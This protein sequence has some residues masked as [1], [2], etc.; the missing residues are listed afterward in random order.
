MTMDFMIFQTFLLRLFGFF[1]PP[2]ATSREISPGLTFHRSQ[3][4]LTGI[5]GFLLL[6]D[7][8]VALI[9]F[10]QIVAVLLMQNGGLLL[11]IFLFLPSFVLSARPMI[12]L[13]LV[14]WKRSQTNS[15][16]AAVQ[17][18]VE[19]SF[20]QIYLRN[21][22]C[23]KWRKTSLILFLFTISI[24]LLMTVWGSQ[25]TVLLVPGGASLTSDNAL[26]PLPVK[27]YLWQYFTLWFLFP[28]FS[29]ILSQQVLV[30]AMLSALVLSDSLK[31]LNRSIRSETDCLKMATKS[32]I[33][34]RINFP[35][36]QR[37]LAAWKSNAAEVEFLFS[38]LNEYFDWILFGIF[39]CD[40]LTLMGFAVNIL[41]NPRPGIDSYGYY[42]LSC[43]VF[44]IY[45]TLFFLPFISL[46]EEV[47][48]PKSQR[49]S[50]KSSKSS[51]NSFFPQFWKI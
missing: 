17:N 33:G 3:K 36:L 28:T 37:T 41:N 7:L 30:L 50:S 44:C 46:H 45:N 11:K 27:F 48:R 20:P 38:T 42:T 31:T 40:F 51:M 18:F 26:Y 16:L 2:V 32:H 24:T 12:V 15:V 6:G 21:Y 35:E 8:I 19:T 5:A 39:G 14:F 10:A 9:L 34:Q 22:Y 29:F 49:I 47:G 25:I 13:T 4:I 43:L 23:K 1:P